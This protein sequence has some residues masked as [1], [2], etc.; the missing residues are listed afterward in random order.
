MVAGVTS[1]VA[2]LVI[3]LFASLG[4]DTKLVR[5]QVLGNYQYLYSSYGSLP[6]GTQP[7]VAGCQKAITSVGGACELNLDGVVAN[8]VFQGGREALR[9]TNVVEADWATISPARQRFELLSGRWP[10][11]PGE[12]VAGPDLAGVT[13]ISTWGGRIKLRVVGTVREQGWRKGSFLL[14]G[15]GTFASWSGAGMELSGVSAQLAVRHDSPDD[16]DVRKAIGGLHVA[17]KL[18]EGASVGP[19]N[20]KKTPYKLQGILALL[21]PALALCVA[22]GMVAGL[23]Q[24]RWA[25]QVHQ[26]LDSVGVDQQLVARWLRSA[27]WRT[28]AVYALGGGLVGYG[29]SWLA[30]RALQ[31]YLGQPLARPV[32]EWF[33][34]LVPLLVVAAGLGFSRRPRESPSRA[35]APRTQTRVIGGLAIASFVS[36]LAAVWSGVLLPWSAAW[37]EVSGGALVALSM[38]LAAP[39]VLH[40][41]G[42]GKGSSAQTQLAFRLLR[43]RSAALAPRLALVVLSV[44]VATVVVVSLASSSLVFSKEARASSPSPKDAIT[45]V[46]VDKRMSAAVP[47]LLRTAKVPGYPVWFAGPDTRGQELVV[48]QDVRA[49]SVLLER[50]LSANER[51]ALEAGQALSPT[52]DEGWIKGSGRKSWGRISTRAMDSPAPF[53]Y[54]RAGL[55]LTSTYGRLAGAP[56]LGNSQYMVLG[57]QPG[58]IDRVT[59]AAVSLGIGAMHYTK[60]YIPPPFKGTLPQRAQP[61]L[62]GAVTLMVTS[63]LMRSLARD[64]RVIRSKLMAL[65]LPSKVGW[66][67]LGL[68]AIVV[69][70]LIAALGTLPALVGMFLSARL[71]NPVM[72][73]WGLVARG[74]LV[75]LV[76]CLAGALL[77]SW[78]LRTKERLG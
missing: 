21:G 70:V 37:I 5:Q 55:T 54:G 72:M 68:Q 39:V 41:I 26:V 16:A 25:V 33:L 8:P 78:G 42:A 28:F 59:A 3:G 20:F 6:I 53:L 62:L 50:P 48:V 1:C 30:T 43:E 35:S 47:T 17:P 67:L 13:A 49:A 65:G 15:P 10:T 14:L 45:V 32:T 60:P 64:I 56:P 61:W 40:L 19:N 4:A 23:T 18:V 24:R 7:D 11:S 51:D 9:V 36:L 31:W 76:A 77:G 22:G 74:A 57:G 66:L 58:D 12:V 44:G 38:A 52:Q 69:A 34:I 73:P 2:L 29:L 63:S 46:T 27:Q 71:G 75:V